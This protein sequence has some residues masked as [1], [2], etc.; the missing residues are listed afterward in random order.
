MAEV[1]FELGSYQT[2][3]MVCVALFRYEES[4]LSTLIESLEI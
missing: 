3:I 4:P 2:Q 1:G